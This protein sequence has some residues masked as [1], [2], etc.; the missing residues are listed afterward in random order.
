MWIKAVENAGT[1][2]TDAIV[3]ITVTGSDVTDRY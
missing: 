2:D 3:H 1:T